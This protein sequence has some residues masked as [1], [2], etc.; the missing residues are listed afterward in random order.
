M[1]TNKYELYLKKIKRIATSRR[2]GYDRQA[3]GTNRRQGY[4]WQARFTRK[5]RGILQEDR[6]GRG[7]INKED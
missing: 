4:G 2:Q 5:E 7:E 3:R 1:D 6:E